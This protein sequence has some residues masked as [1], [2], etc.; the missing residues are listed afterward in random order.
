MKKTVAK[1]LGI[2]ILCGIVLLSA[3]WAGLALLFTTPQ[4]GLHIALASCSA[5]VSLMALAAQF[6]P[7]WR[8]RG[9][10]GHIVHFALVMIWWSTITPSNDRAWQ[11]DVS[12]LPYATV[13]GNLVNIYNIRNFTYRSEFDYEP[14]WYDKQFDLRKLEGVDLVAVYWMGPAI[15]HIFVSFAFTG[16]DHLAISIETRKEKGEDYSTLKGFFRQYE[17]HYVVADERDVI[18]LRTNYRHQPPEDVYVYRLQGRSLENG[19]RV[20]MDYINKINSLKESP[21]FYNTLTTNCTTNIWFHSKG[22]PEH[23]PFSWKIL[24]SGY[25]PQYLYE[26]GMLDSRRPFDE[27]QRSAHVNVQA[28]AADRAADFSQ[29]IRNNKAPAP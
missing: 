29:R 26:S 18:R 10:G 20:F 21:E 7:R 19:R 2:S 11:T 4:T 28:Q 25:V 3:V 27:L 12:V 15:A 16:G 5:L 9:L 22:N 23:L 8:W 14:A 6:S 13:S 24:A 1:I 17:L